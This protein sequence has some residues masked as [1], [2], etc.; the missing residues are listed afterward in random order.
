MLGEVAGEL[1]ATPNQ[2]VLARLM[3]GGIVPV[4]GVST[5]ERLEEAIG[6]TE[7]TL[8]DELRARMDAAC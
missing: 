1:G 7:V 8:D 4:V 5:L 6:A 3:A 2:V